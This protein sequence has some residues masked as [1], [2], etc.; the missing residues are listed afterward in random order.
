MKKDEHKAKLAIAVEA[1]RVRCWHQHLEWQA[2]AVKR[3][4][5]VLNASYRS[6]LDELNKR[7]TS[8]LARRDAILAGANR[9]LGKYERQIGELHR[10][11]NELKK[12]RKRGR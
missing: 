8:E 9:Q 1:M 3:I 10:E 4:S 6:A 7:H 12:G 5:E 2:K 11:I